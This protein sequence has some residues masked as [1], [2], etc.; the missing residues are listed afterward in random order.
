MIW[1]LALTFV[2]LERISSSSN[3]DDTADG[4][5]CELRSCVGVFWTVERACWVT[6]RK[7]QTAL[8]SHRSRTTPSNCSSHKLPSQCVAVRIDEIFPTRQ[9]NASSRS[10]RHRHRTLGINFQSRG[11]Q[12][13]SRKMQRAIA[14]KRSR[15]DVA[16]KF[17][18][19]GDS[20]LQ[21]CDAASFETSLP[22]PAPLFA[23]FD[24]DGVEKNNDC[25]RC[26]SIH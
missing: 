18:R 20:K 4:S 16:R 11:Q 13:T 9:G 15:S 26:L 19:E 24:R 7:C 22:H 5:L 21:T 14:S 17:S 1:S 6:T 10:F 2:A 25:F 23:D 12:V 8:T 3:A